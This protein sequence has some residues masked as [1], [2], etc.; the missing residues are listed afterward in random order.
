VEALVTGLGG[1]VEAF[2]YA[3]GETDLYVIVEVPDHAAAVATALAVDA[4]GAG[5]WRTTVLLTP[6]ELD[7]AVALRAAYRAPGA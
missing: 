7:G 6:E 2:Y 1:R 5:R 3:F 4:S